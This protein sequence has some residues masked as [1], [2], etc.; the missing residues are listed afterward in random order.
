MVFYNHSETNIDQTSILVETNNNGVYYDNFIIVP[1]YFDYTMVNITI[2]IPESAQSLSASVYYPAT[3][4]FDW[5]NQVVIP[6]LIIGAILAVS[7]R[8]SRK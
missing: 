4:S 5:L 3:I 1:S 8:Y 7:I 6:L 2:S